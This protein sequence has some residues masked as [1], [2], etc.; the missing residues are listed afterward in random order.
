MKTISKLLLGAACLAGT[1]AT[2]ADAQDWGGLSASVAVTSDYRF[3][4]ISQNSM[5]VTPQASLTWSLPA[6]IYVG[7]WT[8]KTNWGGNN[9]SFEADFFGGV[10]FDLDGTDLNVQG[11]YYSYP[12]YRGTPAAS[13]YE[14]IVQLSHSFGPLT[15]TATGSESP[16]WSLGGGTGWYG[17]GTA[18]Y[19]VNDW[20]SVSGT[21]GHQSVKAAPADYTHWDFGATATY[22]NLALDLRYVGNDIGSTN[23][24]AFWMATPKACND[25]FVGMLTYTIDPFPG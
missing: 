21:V 8:S 24:A 10:H 5:E 9:P 19:S 20:L 1:F 3:R 16:E 7:T 12:D 13:Y 4:G 2:A 23:C 14:T 22:G 17:A 15:L 11:I 18:S 6:N 25:G